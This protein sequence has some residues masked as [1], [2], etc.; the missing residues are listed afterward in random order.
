MQ[1]RQTHTVQGLPTNYPGASCG[2][3][4]SMP[5][6]L[7]SSILPYFLSLFQTLRKMT[8]PISLWNNES[9]HT[10]S[11]SIMCRKLVMSLYHA[12]HYS[13]I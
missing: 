4:T 6:S 13:L 5:R 8:A 12:G 10:F 7:K 3:S 1:S 11:I 2:T 9:D